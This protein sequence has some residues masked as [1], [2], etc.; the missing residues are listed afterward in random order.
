M[1]YPSYLR[2]FMAL[3]IVLI[4]FVIF[5]SGFFSGMEAALFAASRTKAMVMAEQDLPGSKALLQI[6]ENMSRPIT[7]IV[8]GNNIVNIVGS[9]FVG[10][11]ASQ[12]FGSA[13]LGYLSVALTILIIIFGEIIPKTI[14]ENNA[15]SIGSFVARP[16]LFAT[17][18]LLPIV[19]FIELLTKRFAK[20]RD[21]VSEEELKVLSEL[22]HKEG[23]IEKDERDLIQRVFLMND[24][25]ARDIMTPRTVLVAFQEDQVL[26]EIRDEI[27]SLRH[28]RL[29]VYGEGIDDTTG[30]CLRRD[31][32]QALAEDKHTMKIKDFTHE[33]L[34]VNEKYRVDDLLP[35]FQEK[36]AHM[37]IVKDEF[38]GTS[39]LVTLEDVLEQLVGEIVD[40][41]DEYI[42]AR[43]HAREVGDASGHTVDQGENEVA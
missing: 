32:L 12:L 36:R 14:G 10:V 39:G 28:S 42:D 19:L 22:G 21:L 18:I 6:K 9:L 41:T 16:L 25:V 15:E 1:K 27:F 7:V 33:A 17:K 26:G 38:D 13:I 20:K 43:E 2:P 3:F 24:L 31:L 8:I 11:A 23:V 34:Y 4:L 35:Y 29:P 40:E 30:V 5:G 37:A